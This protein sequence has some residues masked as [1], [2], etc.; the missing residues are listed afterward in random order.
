MKHIHVVED[1]RTSNRVHKIVELMI[2]HLKECEDKEHKRAIIE[3]L[4]DIIDRTKE[5]QK[6]LYKHIEDSDKIIK[7]I[8]EHI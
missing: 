7:I 6:D 1:I 8:Q 2:A 5:M 4:H 3:H